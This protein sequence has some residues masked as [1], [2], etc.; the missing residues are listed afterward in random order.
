[1]T[2]VNPPWLFS[3][4]LLENAEMASLC[5]FHNTIDL[6]QTRAV[7]E[8]CCGGGGM[9]AQ[10]KANRFTF[11][12][13]TKGNTK[14]KISGA[15]DV[16]PGVWIAY[17]KSQITNCNREM[18]WGEGGGKDLRWVESAI[19]WS[20]ASQIFAT[21]S[22]ASQIFVMDDRNKITTCDFAMD[23]TEMI[24]DHKGGKCD[25][26]KWHQTENCAFRWMRSTI[27]A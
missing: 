8:K 19:T 17:H 10:R 16:G 26:G 11:A 15:V 6:L 23:A 13:I 21:R 14:K 5:C 2:G 1:M 22:I 25:G 24:A 9:I 4:D 12:R 18:E 3:A 7:V 20:I 27:N